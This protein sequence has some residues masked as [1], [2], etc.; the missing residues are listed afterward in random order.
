MKIGYTGLI[1]GIIGLALFS[2]LTFAQA[3]EHQP[4]APLREQEGVSEELLP[5]TIK[6]K[7][8]EEYRKQREGEQNL[9]LF[10][11]QRLRLFQER[12]NTFLEEHLAKKEAEKYFEQGKEYFK[13]KRY[14]E[15]REEFERA[16]AVYPEHK[17][18][19]G[20]IQKIDKLELK[21]K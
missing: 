14:S 11:E 20:Y 10:T 8:R 21:L 2:K 7:L 15:A 19:R 16:V 13:Q 17:G 4:S 3:P 6:E 18:A 5:L 1:V 9:L 12:V